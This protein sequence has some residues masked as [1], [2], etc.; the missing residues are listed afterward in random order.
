MAGRF[1]S[2]LIIKPV[3]EH[4]G[5]WE[6]VSKFTY[7]R[8]KHYVTGKLLC[9]I[10]VSSGFITDFASV[11][12]IFWNI[13]PPYGKYGKA[14]VLH[15]W[16]YKKGMYS[17]KESDIIFKEAMV[18]LRVDKWKINVMYYAVRWFGGKVWKKYRKNHG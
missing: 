12:K 6:L 16:L 10:K 2:E 4:P 14:A 3:A 5:Y 13:L 9:P 1:T 17:K 15:D 8:Y 18:V 11:P 7:F